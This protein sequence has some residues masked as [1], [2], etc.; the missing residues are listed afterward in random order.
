MSVVHHGEL[1]VD[2]DVDLP[3]VGAG[4]HHQLNVIQDLTSKI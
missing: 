2:D 4:R 1:I 3:Q